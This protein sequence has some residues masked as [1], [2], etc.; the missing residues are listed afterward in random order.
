MNLLT[1]SL[2]VILDKMAPIKTIQ[3]RKKYCKWLSNQ[4]KLLQTERNHL[5]KIAE[6]TNREDDWKNYKAIR[7]KINNRLK[8]EKKNWQK[9]K[10]QSLDND[11]SQ[12]WKKVKGWLGWSSGGP[13]K[14]LFHNTKEYN[15]PRDLAKIMN[16]FFVDKVKNLRKN[17]P[18]NPGD[19]LE[20]V[21]RLMENRK[22]EFTLEAVHPDCVMKIISKM[23]TSKTVGIDNIDSY[24]IKLAKN[25][26]TPAITHIINL[27]IISRTF[28][29]A[30]KTAKVV[31][32]HKKEDKTSPANYR[33]VA[34]LP[35]LSK[36]LEK[37][38]FLQ[39][40]NYLNENNLLHPSHHGFRAC[41]NTVTALLQMYD[42][43]I[44]AFEKDEISAV[45]L[46]DMSA[47]FDVVDHTI[48]IDKLR[49]YGF[50]ESAILW[51]Q[52]YLFDRYQQVYVDGKLSNPLALEAGVPQGSI[53]GPLLYILFTN[54]LPETIH[55]NIDQI[56]THE[57]EHIERFDENDENIEDDYYKTGLFSACH[58]HCNM[59]GNI[60][61]YADD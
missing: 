30:W 22:C 12:I 55:D 59:C 21:A 53:L 7:N 23:K 19:P 37:A 48:L 9:S 5:Q 8:N 4:T 50:Q 40:I 60:C 27:S 16:E 39:I 57:E 41:H 26:L 56:E 35:T 44:E 29:E 42:S 52:S 38:T 32:L 17:L 31:P 24:V 25:E 51:L 46:I 3:V 58:A 13:P 18:E 28:P 11:P 6:R 33:P 45:V 14:K 43:W 1:E 47:A 34:L 2:T 54:D 10:L 61:C 20:S 15:K 36:I 49:I